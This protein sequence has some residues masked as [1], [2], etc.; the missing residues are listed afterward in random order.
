M[1]DLQPRIRKGRP[2]PQPRVGIDWLCRLLPA[3]CYAASGSFERGP[4][5]SRSLPC[6]FRLP[7]FAVRPLFVAGQRNLRSSAVRA[8]RSSYFCRSSSII[9]W[10]L[11]SGGEFLCAAPLAV[12]YP[13]LLPQSGNSITPGERLARN[14]RSLRAELQASI[15]FS[16]LTVPARVTPRTAEDSQ[17]HIL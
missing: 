14:V 15:N 1:L 8:A 3:A 10:S 11:S 16:S 13:V 17:Q 2:H 12:R 6:R 7:T 5:R 4:G 9:I